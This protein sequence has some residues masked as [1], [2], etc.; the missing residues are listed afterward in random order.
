[1][2]T[3]IREELIL[4]LISI[5]AVCNA[6]MDTIIFHFD[7]M[8]FPKSWNNTSAGIRILGY[9]M[10]PWHYF[11]SIMLICFFICI[12]IQ[13]NITILYNYIEFIVL[14][15]WYCLVFNLFFNKLF[16]KN[17]KK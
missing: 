16:I 12:V 4:I 8:I 6:I 9:P 3:V 1:M 13:P 14:G 17:A 11:K 5:A 10:N 15:V 7:R 2:N